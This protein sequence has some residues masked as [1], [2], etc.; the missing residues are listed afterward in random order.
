MSSPA[1]CNLNRRRFLHRALL[2]G[3][4]PLLGGCAASRSGS[5]H[6]VHPE[7]DIIDPP[8]QTVAETTEVID[9]AAQACDVQPAFALPDLAQEQVVKFVA[10]VRPY[11]RQRVRIEAESLD[12]KTLIHNYGHGGAGLTLAWGSASETVRL[13]RS[14]MK[15]PEPPAEIAV[16]GA[17]VI[18]LTAAHELLLAGYH[19]RI[20][21]KAT[22]D[23]TTSWLAGGQWAPSLVARGNPENDDQFFNRILSESHE[24]YSMLA[25]AGGWGV[26]RRPNLVAQADEAGGGG[27]GGGLQHIPAHL[28]PPVQQYEHLPLQGMRV[29][30]RVYQTMLIE[31][32]AFLQ[33]LSEQVQSL[34]GETKIRTFTSLEEVAQLTEPVIVNC[35]GLG[36]RDIVDDNLLVPMKGNLVYLQ[37]QHLPY[38]LSHGSGYMFPRSDAVVLGGSVERGSDSDEPDEAVCLR[39]LARHRRFFDDWLAV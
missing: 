37:P 14:A 6:I 15:P 20:Y 33:R 39:I 27:G 13:V 30:G 5:Q 26:Y 35:L 36:A 24:R 11:R 3:G 4:L 21:T 7:S 29:A 38:L 23:R 8:L 32:S 28:M 12:T 16:L 25:D 2:A 31:P 17:G 34:G 9:R 10:G 1:Q 22:L 19:V 18:G